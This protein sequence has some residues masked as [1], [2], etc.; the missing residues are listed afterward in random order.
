MRVQAVAP[1]TFRVRLNET[2]RFVETALFR[3][4]VV[5]AVNE[6]ENTG[7]EAPFGGNAVI[8]AGRAVLRIDGSDGQFQLCDA[9]GTERLRTCG[10]PWSS[11][12]SGFGVQLQL[13]ADEALYG[14]GNIAPEQLQRRG[15]HVS[16]WAERSLLASAPIPFLMSSRGWAIMMNTVLKHEFDIGYTV[17]ERLTIEGQKGELDFF[18]FTGNGYGELLDTYT[19]IAGKPQLLPIWMYG[20]NFCPREKSSARDVLEDAIKFRRSGTPCDLIGLN[21]DWTET[22]NDH[23]TAKRWH[24]ER[25]PTSK[26]DLLRK[27]SF[28]GILQ[29]QGFKLSLT[30]GCD[31]DLTFLEEKLAAGAAEEEEEGDG[32]GDGGGEQD[33]KIEPW[34]DHLQK[35]VDDGIAAF[36]AS[37]MNPTYSHPERIWGN[38]MS[39]A[40]LHNLYPVLL[41]KQ[42][43]RG[44]REQTNM[45][46]VVHMERGYLGMQQFVAST[47]GTFYN[48]SQ[49]I[50]ALLNYGLSGHA[51]TS[52]NMHLITR[53]G[54][55]SD[56]LLTWSRIYSQGHFH[57]PDFL[58][59]SLQQLFNTYAR[60]RYRLIPYIYASAHVAARTGMPVTRAMPLMYP[61][62]RNCRELCGQY[63]LG[64]FLLVVVYTD[65]V[66]LPEG[67]WIDY[68]TGERY[69][70]PQT[71]TYRLPPQA[72]GP[73]FVRAGAI[74]PLWPAMDYIGQLQ[75][76]TLTLD[77]Y[78]GPSGRFVLYEDDGATFDYVDGHVARTVIEWSADED[79]T[80]VRIS[81]RE[82][83]YAGMAAKR[84]YEL[85]VHTGKKPAAVRVGGQ[86]RPDQTRRVKADLYRG[87]RYDRLAGTVRLVV[88]EAGT[89][90]AAVCV[91]LVYPPELG[92]AVGG[93]VRNVS[94]ERSA[95]EEE[96]DA[97]AAFIAALD[98]VDR[99]RAE[100]ALAAWWEARKKPVPQAAAAWLVHVM[101]GCHLIV[102]HAERNGW[103]VEDV[104]GQTADE[105][106]AF[107]QLQTSEQGYELLQRLVRGFIQHAREQR[108]T[109]KHPA[110]RELFAV[111]ERELERDL[112]LNAMAERLALHPFHLSRLFKKETGRAYSD[113]VMSMRMKRARKLLEAGHKVY[114]AAVRS[115]FADA[116]NFS[117]AFSKYWGVPPISFKP[118]RE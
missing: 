93:R 51:N 83:A 4:R 23:S 7:D 45:R 41:G 77:V 111:V 95:G 109:A 69:R 103:T 48:A 43:H 70:G 12:S 37:T 117:K 105:T 26:N 99:E 62:D 24:P 56:F 63:M 5:N 73:L 2:G 100:A 44:F 28:I 96:A 9:D 54:I 55:H 57:H 14:L 76:E 59:R 19:D 35:F 38:G 116:G 18:F 71:F 17:A 33:S 115:G 94:S 72:G 30:V 65:Q 89:E 102:R 113:Y 50:T 36:V 64:D 82:G 67:E 13:A 58:E 39:S 108:P 27:V 104:F 68:W 61:D 20:L 87:W 22:V 8:E 107:T 78:P 6:R 49:A 1:G 85:V 47:T 84:S 118:K 88:D 110:I 46:P 53:E 32:Y 15:L 40:E 74:I 106:F 60:L 52:T 98:A 114:E 29:K 79:T 11:E 101:N 97:D 34:Y 42:M 91:E 3:Y 81:R 112:S 80:T 16:M 25:F 75:A 31:Y 92:G 86:R 66:Y 10:S 90:E 21:S